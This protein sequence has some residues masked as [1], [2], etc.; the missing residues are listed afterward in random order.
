MTRAEAYLH[1]KWHLDPSSR[2]S[3]VHKRHGLKIGGGA[4]P[5]LGAHESPSNTMWP[6]PRPTFL[7]S[8]I[9]IHPLQPFGYNTPTSQTDRQTVQRSDSTGRTVLQTVDEKRLNRSVCRLDC[10]LGRPKEA[11]VQSYSPVAPMRP[12]GRAYW[13]YLANTIE[14]S[15]CGGDAVLYEITLTTCYY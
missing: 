15:I 13:C 8:F 5:F 12:H 2:L 9:L 1:N 14:P 11:Q 10:G 3:S 7:P 6:K 4:L